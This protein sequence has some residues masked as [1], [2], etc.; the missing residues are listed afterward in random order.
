MNSFIR[1]LVLHH[2]RKKADRI[3]TCF[4]LNYSKMKINQDRKLKVSVFFDDT[5]VKPFVDGL[6]EMKCA[7]PD[8]KTADD[9]L[10]E[11]ASQLEHPESA[12]FA[13][14]DRELI[15]RLDDCGCKV[16][17][18]GRIFDFVSSL[19]FT[20]EENQTLSDFLGSLKLDN[21]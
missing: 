14:S 9:A 1:D 13:T 4:Y 20:V 5:K 3:L 16:T 15:Q 21:L 12:M 2:N 6:F 7:R 18:S 8:F 11:V 17:K 19:L 10:V